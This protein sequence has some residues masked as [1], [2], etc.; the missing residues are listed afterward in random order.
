MGWTNWKKPLTV[1]KYEEDDTSFDIIKPHAI[2]SKERVT[3]IATGY[4]QMR[5]SGVDA[6]Y[7]SDWGWQP[8]QVLGIEVKTHVS[9][10]ARITD[11]TVQLTEH[12]EPVGKNLAKTY[13]E[14][15]TVYGGRLDEWRIE[16]I[17]PLTI[18]LIL[19]YQPHPNYPSSELVYIRSV[20]MRILYKITDT[21][22]GT[23]SMSSA[24][25]SGA[26][27]GRSASGHVTS[28]LASIVSED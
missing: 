7:F 21:D 3:G 25:E 26:K 12:G 16:N 10:L 13:A 4:S 14:N 28:N 24:I 11:L 2:T 19:D 8:G 22:S 20:H 5:T 17:D 23:T 27:L 9:R 15:I 6:V 1:V 18:G